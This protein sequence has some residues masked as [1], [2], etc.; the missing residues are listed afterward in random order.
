MR[1]VLAAVLA[2]IAAPAFAA[3]GQAVFIDKCG[4]CHTL[5]GP[6]QTAPS[7]KGVVGRK[8][9]SLAD[10]Q[11][12]DALKAK[13]GGTWDEATLGSFLAD[14]K[15][16]APGTV[17]FGGAPDPADRQAIIDYLKSAK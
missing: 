15:A 5:E 4:D 9:A 2:L 13:S 1:V 3:T 16:F 10:F 8:I 17:M 11:Y 12:S 7:L 14:P 6:S